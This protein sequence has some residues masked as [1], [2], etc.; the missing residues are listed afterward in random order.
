MHPMVTNSIAAKPDVVMNDLGPLAWVLNELCKS[1]EAATKALRRFTKE[2]EAARGS[3]LA[4]MDA[5]QLRAARQQLHQ[6][7][8]VLE[9]VGLAEPAIVLRAMEV[10]VQ[11]FVQQPE[12]C[13]QDAVAKIEYASFALTEYLEG[14]LADKPFS[15]VSLFP[16]YRD[17]QE[18]VRAD[19]I[20]PADLWSYEWRWLEPE[21]SPMPEPHSYG[22]DA[23]EMLDKAILQ[24]MKGKAPQAAASLRDLGLGFAAGQTQRQPRI[25]WLLAAGFFEAIA[26][27]LLGSDL[28]VRRAASRVLLQYA[29]LSRGEAAIPERLVLDLLFFCFQAVSGRASDTPVLS[30]VRFAYGL[31]RFKPVDYELVQFG[32]FDPALLAQARKRIV[33]AKDAWSSLC[34]GEITKIKQVADQFSLVTDS[35]RKLHAASEP[36]AQALARAIETTESRKQ[37][38]AIA[39]AME[40]ATSMLYLEAVFDDLDPSDPQLAIRTASLAERLEDVIDGGAPQPLE[41]W[42]EEL[43][44]RVS[45]KQTMSSVV[46]ELRVALAEVESSLDLFFR[47]SRDKTR[48]QPVPRQLAQ[49]RGVLSVLGLDQASRAVLQMKGTV[50]QMLDT[51]IDDQQVRAAGTFEQLG[52]NL[53]VL[54]FL[55][56][57]LNYQ[58]AL[59]KK[60]FVYDEEKDQL[61]SLMGRP[62]AAGDA[63]SSITVNIEPLSPNPVVAVE[64]TTDKTLHEL[65][66]AR[67]DAVS[68]LEGVVA[69]LADEAVLHLPAD[70]PALTG[71]M[72]I[73]LSLPPATLETPASIDFEEDDLRDIFLEEARE[74]A[75]HAMLAIAMLE[76]H[77]DDLE[78]LTV[79][80]RAFHT[81]K[82]SA[83]MVGLDEFGEAS[84]AMEQLLNSWLADQNAASSKFRALCSEVMA[85]L[86]RWIGDIEGNQDGAWSALAFCDSAQAMRTDGRYLALDL[87]GQSGKVQKILS[88][89]DVPVSQ[90]APRIGTGFESEPM[91]EFFFEEET[92]IAATSRSAGQADLVPVELEELDFD[93]LFP[94]AFESSALATVADSVNAS[95]VSDAAFL[96]ETPSGIPADN[97]GTRQ[98]PAHESGQP[99]ETEREDDAIKV[100]DGLRIGIP[101]YNVY[102]NEADEWSRRLVIEVAE[103]ALE[104]HQPISASSVALAHSLAGSSATVGFMALSD[105]ARALEHALENSRNHHSHCASAYGRLFIEASEDVRRLLNQFAAGFLKQP[106]PG[107]LERLAGLEFSD[108]V[109]PETDDAVLG[110]FDD[111]IP[112][113]NADLPLPAESSLSRLGRV[114]S[115]AAYDDID[116]IDDI[117]AVDVIDLDLFPI[118]EEEC[119]E[120]M[121]RLG[122][123]L[124]QWAR[125]P[126][127]SGPRSEVSRVLHTLKGSA[128]LAGA[129][130]LGEMAHR[131]ESELT[132]IGS[133]APASQEIEFLLTRF[134][135]MQNAFERLRR[136]DA[137]TPQAMPTQAE[138]L[139]VI[140]IEPDP[141]DPY[142]FLSKNDVEEN[143]VEISPAIDSTRYAASA[144]VH[145]RKIEIP[146]PQAMVMQPLRQAANASIRVR[147]Q[148]LDRMVNQA[149]EVMISRSRLEAEVGQLRMSLTDMTGSLTRLRQQLRDIELQ[150]ETQMQSRLA[151]AK[152]A[153]AGFDP[154]EFDRFTRVQ[155]LTRMMAESVNDVATV[156]RTIQRTIEATEDDLVAQGRQA[157]ELQR[158][159]LR[160]R[161]VQFES[162]SERL[163]RVVR[164]TS[165]ET[166][167]QVR[168]DLHGGNLEMDR[169]MLDRMMPA[170]EHLLRNCLTHGIEAPQD[171]IRA[172]KD[173]VG[174]ITIQLRQE[175]NDIS[176]QLGDDGAGL[177][178]ARIRAQGIKQGLVTASQSTDNE[179]TA[180]LIFLPGFSTAQEVTELAG[181][182]IGL[183]VVRSEV[184]SLGGRIKTSTV[185][186]KGTEFTMVLPLTTA[187]TQVVMLRAGSMSVGVPANVVETVRR[188]TAAELQ[189]AYRSGMLDV[190]GESVPF[191]WSG[192]LLQASHFSSEAQA[193]TTPVVV[194]RS[195]AQRIAMHVD[196]VLGNREVVVK[197]LGP[198]LSGLPGLTG[199]SMLPS[200]AVVLIYNPVAL[201]AVYGKQARVWS[202]DYLEQAGGRPTGITAPALA[203]PRAPLILVVD[204]SIT[205]RR[206]TQRMLLRDGYRVV[207]AADGLQALERLH[208]ELPA[209]VLSDIEMPRMDGFDLARNIRAD[210][211]MKGL[212][213]IMITSR[214]AGKHNEHA[215]ELGVNHYLGKPY[216]EDELL[217][218]I[219][220]YCSVLTAVPV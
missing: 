199:M 180:N 84:W 168:L 19:R 128:R 216:S 46:S 198:Q 176:V 107:I 65:P 32:R 139:P 184:I 189:Q 159:L 21:V 181:R 137:A 18:L 96:P 200:G 210:E 3:D 196:E 135:G 101:L 75:G 219:R 66:G 165:K 92:G 82:G 142:V 45:D 57:M 80:R 86:E 44:R 120:L 114:I 74:V 64:K 91:S 173:A 213:I 217:G 192:A 93:S 13:S 149:G 150:A 105:L 6:A 136:L 10:A 108:S 99:D 190:S 132:S 177:D 51:E 23:R 88:L 130:R 76:S 30:A 25:F 52:N 68:S 116:D 8:G 131:I 125:A 203:A 205:V 90:T 161:M 34:A 24:L 43:Y 2:T 28:Y 97:S 174:L 118:F 158:D 102:V 63:A 55:I 95:S 193:K 212:P 37:V 218:L 202:K 110:G 9:V 208:E 185:A 194:F 134:D 78:Q 195:A 124:R 15:A 172:G 164:Q 103:W 175:G 123:A 156:Q 73:E 31:A 5:S 27:N 61:T 17:V 72:A 171:R 152:E 58:P 121:P 207:M 155:E 69:P 145:A 41:A 71:T 163:Y 188:A 112:A 220:Q 98:E 143:D 179:A 60:L 160:T 47:D 56:D 113:N 122:S 48:L 215:V 170:F 214:I 109:F 162:V 111:L 35:L 20:H 106:L 4:A 140:A 11:K 117:D 22:D 126:A 40:V 59:V 29:A 204:D 16:Q 146:G 211:R 182:G 14:I 33:L 94:M 127:D 50:E 79:L 157:R 201:A 144:N 151:L 153:K 115:Q 167:K 42:M 100:I 49:M 67:L 138:T 186:G 178:L 85:G 77:P 62:P 87:S 197:N 209:V 53:G 89:G 1:L 154:L 206:V 119:A 7:V 183:D 26:H 39:M 141:Q 104:S 147:T 191:F 148:L 169:G 129:M 83:R 38:P 81:L 133:H 54:S 70:A 36:L 187:V 12:L 166:G